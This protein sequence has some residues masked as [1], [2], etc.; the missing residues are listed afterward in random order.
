MGI[1]N[2]SNIA[3]ISGLW[4]AL[5]ATHSNS[6]KSGVLHLIAFPGENQLGPKQAGK[7]CR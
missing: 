4:G 3:L 1:L 7:E 2:H 5:H 6:T